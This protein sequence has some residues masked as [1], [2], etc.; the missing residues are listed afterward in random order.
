VRIISDYYDYYDGVQSS[1]CH[2]D[3]PKIFNRKLNASKDIVHISI[4]HRISIIGGR[5]IVV[6]VAGKLYLGFKKDAQILNGKSV[7][8]PP[9]FD[10]EKIIN[11]LKRNSSWF[12]KANVVNFLDEIKA[13]EK[14]LNLFYE[15]NTPIFIAICD[16]Y[17]FFS[18][19][20]RFKVDYSPVLK[21]HGFFRVLDP[22]TI[23]Q[24]I[25]MFLNNE[26]SNVNNEVSVITDNVVLRDSKGFDTWSFKTLP[27]KRGN[28]K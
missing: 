4:N 2:E 9:T 11:G 28:K 25:D 5:V 16:K 22:F 20:Y 12:D 1:F 14:L 15:K 10:E 7:Q 3:S 21:D 8:H 6:G 23:F 26:L 17:D 19:L 27:S 18:K 13:D 24:E